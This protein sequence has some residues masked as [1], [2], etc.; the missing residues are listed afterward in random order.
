MKANS[1]K[2]RCLALRSSL[3]LGY[4]SKTWNHIR[5]LAH[6]QHSSEEK[7]QLCRAV[8]DTVPI[9]PS[10]ESNPRSVPL[11]MSLTTTPTKF[12]FTDGKYRLIL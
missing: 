1:Q 9:L 8:G 11:A 10:E 12:T 2:Q 7:S 3:Y 4:Y 6:A 5:G